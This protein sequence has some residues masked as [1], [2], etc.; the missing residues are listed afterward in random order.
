MEITLKVT[1]NL[2]FFRT[3]LLGSLF[4]DLYKP[5]DT[6]KNIANMSTY[7]E[8]GISLYYTTY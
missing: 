6:S 5:N 4:W 8:G 1:L 2:K 7:F 3:I